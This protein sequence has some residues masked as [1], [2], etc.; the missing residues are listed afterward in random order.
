[1]HWLYPRPV[2]QA[3]R[4][5]RRA[6]AWT[7]TAA[8]AV[9]Y[10]ILAPPSADLAAAAYR[11]TLFSHVGFTL[12]DNSWY[13]GHHLLAYSVLAPALGA[14]I[15]PQPLAAI[16]MV[17]AT[18]LFA[19]LIDGHFPTRAVRSGKRPLITAAN[20]PTATTIDSAASGCGPIS[21]PNAGIRIE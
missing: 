20:R 4:L 10:L 9:V 12:W 1:M 6:P 5:A 16:S 2:S 7:I 11:S 18:G 8:F 13:G 3:I 17:I 14:L 15:G 21:A 19:L